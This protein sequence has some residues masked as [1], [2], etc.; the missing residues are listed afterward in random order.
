M[1]PFA[2]RFHV[3]VRAAAGA[4]TAIR[5]ALEGAGTAVTEVRVIPTTLEDAFL[6]LTTSTAAT[7]AA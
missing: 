2:A 1:R 4:E 3:R 5:A 7:E 6:H